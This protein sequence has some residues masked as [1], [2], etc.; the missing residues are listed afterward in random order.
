MR[1]RVPENLTEIL[2]ERRSNLV[3][4]VR[5]SSGATRLKPEL[6]GVQLLGVPLRGKMGWDER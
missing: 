4:D 3:P 5:F 2:V 6:D 1:P